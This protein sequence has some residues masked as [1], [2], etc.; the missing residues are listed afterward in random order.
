MILYKA[1]IIRKLIQDF[2]STY[3]GAR[4]IY[5]LRGMAM[6]DYLR[7]RSEMHHHLEYRRKSALKAKKHARK[8]HLK[9]IKS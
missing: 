3:D 6:V 8:Q 4:R 7:S 5:E 2:A 1:C 9:R